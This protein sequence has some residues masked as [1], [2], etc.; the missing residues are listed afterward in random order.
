MARDYILRMVEQIA[1][2]LATILAKKQAGKVAEAE[3]EVEN[4]CLQTIGLK[5]ADLKRL[6]PEAVE[7][8]L[9]SAG[10]LRPVR[11][12][13]LAELLLVDAEMHEASPNTMP[14]VVSNYVHAFCLFAD[15]MDTLT[16]EEQ[17]FYR[18]K[19][20]MVAD[21]LGALREHPYIKERLRDY[22][23]AKSA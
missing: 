2:L 18:A 4:V 21:R 1:A 5:L 7:D 11:A 10:A 16:T 15:A 8:L 20:D 9:K 17:T 23:T 12:I 22:G 19:L 6:S 13:T 3:T 14:P